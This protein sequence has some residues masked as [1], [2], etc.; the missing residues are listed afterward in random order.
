MQQPVPKNINGAITMVEKLVDGVNANP[1][2]NV[3]HNTKPVLLAKRQEAVNARNNY[4]L[5]KQSLRIVRDSLEQWRLKSRA[6]IMLGRDILKPDLGNDFNVNWTSLGFDGSLETAETIDALVLQ[7]EAFET[8]F[9]ANPTLEVAAKDITAEKA[10]ELH[11]ALVSGR[12]ALSDK[13]TEVSQL[14]AARDA[15]FEELRKR[16]RFTIDE[17][18]G[19]LDPLDLRWKSF[20]LNI[21]DAEETP[22][23]PIGLSAILVGPNAAAMKWGASARAEYYRVWM[24]IHGSDA[25]PTPMGSPADLDFTLE[26]LPANSTVDVAVS[27]VN[28]GGES[29]LSE[30]VS[31]M[32]H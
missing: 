7:T 19:L 5:S 6:M 2:L 22:D 3:V 21:P 9:T 13:E 32:T 11:D 16:I 26:N 12:Q 20:G 14:L 17:L 30:F 10:Q 27:A 24:K 29:A 4:E 23:V 18:S 1:T 28:N 8:F 31:V 15:K 25:E